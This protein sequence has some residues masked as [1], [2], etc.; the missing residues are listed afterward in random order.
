MDIIL[1]RP[2][3]D[4]WYGGQAYQKQISVPSGLCL[5]A[6]IL[7]KLGIK[8][9]IVDGINQS[10]DRVIKKIN[11]IKPEFVGVTETYAQH[12]NALMILEA[13]KNYGAKTIIGGPNVTFL[14]KNI[15]F[16]RIYVDYVVVGDGEDALPQ[17]VLK[18][19]PTEIPNLFYRDSKAI[20]RNNPVKTV[21]MEHLFNLSNIKDQSIIDKT[22][23]C[24]ISIV[25]GCLYREKN[26][27]R[28]CIFCSCNHPLKIMNPELAWNQ[29]ALLNNLYGFKY[30]GDAGDSFI[31]P[32]LLEKLLTT[33]PK[34]LSG[35]QFR[36]FAG[37]EQINKGIAK[38]LQA[39]NVREV[40]LGLESVDDKILKAAGKAYTREIIDQ[41]IKTLFAHN[42]DIQTP[43][44]FGL[45]H[46]TTDSISVSLEYAKSLV[47]SKMIK[48]ITASYPIPFPGTALFNNIRQSISADEYH[49][50]LYN[51]DFFN[52]KLL[53]ELLLKYFTEVN[54]EQIN[55][56]IKQTQGLMAESGSFGIN[57]HT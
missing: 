49:G 35:I 2:P 13:A 39:L 44:I 54:F 33:R 20:I 43:F 45:P 17:I 24:P 42:I 46:E 29:I 4:D 12:L 22:N 14:A 23:L 11:A 53:V 47:N 5:L 15:L 40:F 9:M 41:A 37:P 27:N 6:T 34:K 18:K 16:R 57:N 1:V 21:E 51:D 7:T 56:A 30:F 50:D 26:N 32:E 19:S 48:K 8:T 3:L 52:Y 28:G 25:R 55:S 10:V 38:L 36:I 31:I